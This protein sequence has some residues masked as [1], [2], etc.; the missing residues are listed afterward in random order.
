VLA[1]I[2]VAGLLMIVLAVSGSVLRRS[3]EPDDGRSTRDGRE[4]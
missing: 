4:G 1:V 3:G 2:V